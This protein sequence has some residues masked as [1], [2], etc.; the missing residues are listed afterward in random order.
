MADPISVA[1]LV[2]SGVSLT[3]Q[4]FSGCIKGYELLLRANN[5]P[6]KYHYLRIRLQMEQH[7]LL[8]W[9]RFTDLSERDET[10]SLGLRLNRQVLND[11]LHEQDCL[12]SD[13]ESLERKYGL[14]VEVV[15]DRVGD[16]SS[17][18]EQEN[19]NDGKD[20]LMKGHKNPKR[21]DKLKLKALSW[22]ENSRRYPKHLRWAAFDDKRFEKLLDNLSVLNNYLRALMDSHQ[23]SALQREQHQTS[24]Q[25]LQLNDKVD[26]LL[27]IF[28]T[29]SPS[30]ERKGSLSASSTVTTLIGYDPQVKAN[31]D[32]ERNKYEVKLQRL[33]RFKALS[34]AVESNSLYAGHSTDFEL[35]L[36]SHRAVAP[37]LEGMLLQLFEESTIAFERKPSR[38]NALYNSVPVWV[39]WKY[40]E[41]TGPSQEPASFIAGRVSKLAALLH[42]PEK[43]EEFRVPDCLG[44]ITDF[45]NTRYGFVFKKLPTLSEK[46]LPISL[47]QLLMR[48][49]RPSLTKRLELARALVTCIWY[50]HATDWLH[51]GLRSD[52]IVF[53]KGESQIDL[54]QPYL[55]GFDYARPAKRNEVTELPPNNPEYDI[56]RHP[57]VHGDVPRDGKRGYKMIYDIYSIGIVLLEIARWQPIAA[58]AGIR[59]LDRNTKPNETKSIRAKILNEDE[60]LDVIK[61]DF[62]DKFMEAV[63]TCLSGDFGVDKSWSDEENAVQLQT[64]FYDKVVRPLDEILV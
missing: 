38:S 27:Q 46:A 35:N 22:I 44:Y 47:Y 64:E 20:E 36:S 55:S 29:T 23:R 50:L 4:V 30:P 21:E 26:V 57:N 48:Q 62:G 5:M 13:L 18:S 49:K 37:R 43:P 59:K 1:G 34:I 12:L 33:A 10:L 60:Y 58:I 39:E 52:N 11:I 63:R 14:K 53:F 61:A 51:K 41:P 6:Q 15:R 25:V 28:G 56:Y 42:D 31:D 3:F 7:K 45:K 40:Y 8:D 54:S 9:A 2:L 32:V 16:G 24:M 19:K 17:I